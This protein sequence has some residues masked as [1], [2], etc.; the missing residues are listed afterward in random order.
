MPECVW[1]H[2]S[3]PRPHWYALSEDE[4]AMLVESW[5]RVRSRSEAGGARC[6]GSYHVRGQ[7]DFQEV[8]IWIF[9][10]SGAAFA[11]WDGLCSERYNAFFAFANNLGLAKE[12]ADS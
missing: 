7:H 11:H 9:P 5:S 6:Q 1:I 12:G 2:Y 8:E 4:Q 3:R 10:D